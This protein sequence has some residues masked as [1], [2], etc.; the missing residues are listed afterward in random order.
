MK[1]SKAYCI[2]SNILIIL[3][4]SNLWEE[5]KLFQSKPKLSFINRFGRV[6]YSGDKLEFILQIDGLSKDNKIYLTATVGEINNLLQ[7]LIKHYKKENI[8]ED[9][10]KITANYLSDNYKANNF[11]FTKI[12]NNYKDWRIGLVDSLIVNNA[13]ENNLIIVTDDQR[14][15]YPLEEKYGF[16]TIVPKIFYTSKHQF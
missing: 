16:E 2:D 14:T 1:I 10:Y 3:V 7:P 12:E 13:I 15:I 11:D 9:I 6:D 5:I 8:L 4:L